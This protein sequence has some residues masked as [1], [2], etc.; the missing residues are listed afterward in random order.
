METRL[1][2]PLLG[3]A[4]GKVAS[5]AKGAAGRPVGQPHVSL[6]RRRLEL[7]EL[8]LELLDLLAQ[9]LLDLAREIAHRLAAELV[10]MVVMRAVCAVLARGSSGGER[11]VGRTMLAPL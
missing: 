1:K 2:L 8:L 9:L 4:K 11:D 6:L 3:D 10:V 5:I 7:Q